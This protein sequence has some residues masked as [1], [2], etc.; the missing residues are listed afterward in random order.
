MTQRSSGLLVGIFVI[1]GIL[2]GIFALGYFGE[3]QRYLRTYSTYLTFF[4]ESVDGLDVKS[5]VM[6]EGLEI[7]H[8][9]ALE[10]AQDP[11]YIQ[12]TLQLTRP[13][14]ITEDVY[15]QITSTGF[16]GANFVNI[17]PGLSHQSGP[18]LKPDL[19][20][21]YPVIASRP[22]E[23]GDLMS[24]VQDI[25]RQL[26]QAD[27]ESTVEEI[28]STVRA[29]GDLLKSERLRE[30]L[31]RLDRSS[32]NLEETLANLNQATAGGELEQILSET[33]S[34]LSDLQAQ[35]EAANIPEVASSAQN[36]LEDFNR[37]TALV[38]TEASDTLEELRRAVDSINRL[39][40]RLYLRPSDLLY[41]R[42]PPSRRGN[43]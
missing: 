12:V 38:G 20:V 39:V 24:A 41:S 32:R 6:Y 10:V 27:L 19:R 7:G 4:A 28:D 30:I 33:R 43:R 36:A 17:L 35:A 18:G 22:S 37:Q 25:A 14:L 13:E 1:V 29:A 26:Q 23:L 2:I 11:R 3:G 21:G 16:T 31:A 40:E 8:V 42:P 5:P 9:Q 34:L 15:T